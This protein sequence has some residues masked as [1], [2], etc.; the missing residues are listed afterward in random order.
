M[1]TLLWEEP[2][3]SHQ[4]LLSQFFCSGYLAK[5]ALKSCYA[6]AFSGEKKWQT[7]VM[8]IQRLNMQMGMKVKKCGQNISF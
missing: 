2:N 8:G 7:S 1:I 4:W 3:S 6:L 5:A